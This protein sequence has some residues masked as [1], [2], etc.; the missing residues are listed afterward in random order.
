MLGSGGHEQLVRYAAAQYKSCLLQPGSE[1][2][3]TV[4]RECMTRALDAAAG[5]GA[6]AVVE[7]IDWMAFVNDVYETSKQT[8]DELFPDS[9]PF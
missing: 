8:I 5:A 3:L 2:T 4:P 9:M 7:H 1:E 6:S